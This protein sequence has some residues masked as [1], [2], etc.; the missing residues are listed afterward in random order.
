[1]VGIVSFVRLCR[2]RRWPRHLPCISCACIYL[3]RKRLR[4]SATVRGRSWQATQKQLDKYTSAF[5]GLRLGPDQKLPRAVW[6]HRRRA[7]EL[8]SWD[9]VRSLQHCI[10]YTV[11]WISAVQAAASLKHS[12]LQQISELERHRSLDT[13]LNCVWLLCLRSTKSLLMNR[14]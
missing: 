4:H 12:T 11:M 9:D 3:I 10:V 13:C 5:M 1:M 14:H 7:V 6:S 8:P 2:A